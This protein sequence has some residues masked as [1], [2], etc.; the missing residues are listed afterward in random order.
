MVI[1]SAA[2]VAL[3]KAYRIFGHGVDSV[4]LKIYSTH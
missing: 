1:L 2:A 3:D 4:F